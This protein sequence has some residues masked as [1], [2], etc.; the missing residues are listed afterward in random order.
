MRTKKET[1]E[2]GCLNDQIRQEPHWFISGL[3]LP[4]LYVWV[5]VRRVSS[6]KKPSLIHP[7]TSL[8]NRSVWVLCVANQSQS[9][10]NRFPPFVPR[11]YFGC[12]R[13]RNFHFNF[14]F[15]VESVQRLMQKIF[16][17]NKHSE[18]SVIDITIA[19]VNCS[20]IS[21]LPPLLLV[22]KVNPSSTFYFQ[23]Y[24]Y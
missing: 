14:G 24:K 5:R 7:R 16:S 1:R 18:V 3:S 17:G 11:M 23:R 13:P 12:A 10:G 9:R 6:D 8:R 15:R 21:S 2:I 4:N 19:L 22:E 20:L